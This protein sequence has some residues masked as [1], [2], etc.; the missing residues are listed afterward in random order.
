MGPGA[1]IKVLKDDLALLLALLAAVLDDEH[2]ALLHC[3]A[4]V[5]G[6]ELAGLVDGEEGL[7]LFVRLSAFGGMQRK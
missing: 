7:H 3:Q 4:R 2:P 6:D 5:F 1:F